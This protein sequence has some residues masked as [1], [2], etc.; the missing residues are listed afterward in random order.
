MTDE[1]EMTVGPFSFNVQP[2]QPDD[3]SQR[4]EDWINA[5][6]DQLPEPQPWQKRWWADLEGPGRL[7][8]IL[9]HHRRGMPDTPAKENTQ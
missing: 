2:T 9:P 3:H 5:V 8:V 4:L 6:W 7:I 1:E